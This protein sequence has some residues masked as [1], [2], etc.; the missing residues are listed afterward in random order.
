[1][2]PYGERVFAA[3][4]T[5][6]QPLSWNRK[7]EEAGQRRR[8]FLMSLGDFFERSRRDE[9]AWRQDAAAQRVAKLWARTPWLDWLI[10]TK[11]PSTMRSWQRRYRPRGLPP[12]VWAGVSV[13]DAICYPRIAHLIDTKAALRFVSVEP[14]LGPVELS[15]LGDWINWVIVGGESGPQARPMRPDWARRIRDACRRAHVPFFFKQWGEWAPVNALD[16]ETAVVLADYDRHYWH[17]IARSSFRVGR[18][19]AGRKLDGR[20]WDEVPE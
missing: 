19:R 20:T 15:C 2:G 18:K 6:R 17:N 1:M 10:L 13:E 4:S 7:A 8:V 12:N 5:W 9:I 14:L 16:I 3:E 11:R